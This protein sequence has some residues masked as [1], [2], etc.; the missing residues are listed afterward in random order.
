MYADYGEN[1]QQVVT[2]N[3]IKAKC[4]CD[5]SYIVLAYYHIF[6]IKNSLPFQEIYGSLFYDIC[7]LNT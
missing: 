6:V 3:K 7:T 1:K 4:D 5:S 2:K